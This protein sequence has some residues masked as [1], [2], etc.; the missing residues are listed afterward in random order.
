MKPVTYIDHIKPIQG[1]IEKGSIVR[2][3]QNG[4]IGSVY[5]VNN[6]TN[7]L[8][9]IIIQGNVGEDITSTTWSRMQVELI[10]CTIKMKQ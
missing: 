7:T 1:A 2:N 4:K 6:S 10:Q 8:T 5:S 3:T 9:I